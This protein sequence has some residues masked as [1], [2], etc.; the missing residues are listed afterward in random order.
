MAKDVLNLAKTGH[1]AKQLMLNQFTF[2]IIDQFCTYY[3]G[4]ILTLTNAVV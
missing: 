2:D 3:A 1:T 4:N